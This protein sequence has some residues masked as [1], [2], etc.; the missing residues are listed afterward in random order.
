MSQIQQASL[1]KARG[2]GL[3]GGVAATARPSQMSRGPV[4]AASAEGACSRSGEVT[5]P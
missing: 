4:P 1:G 5:G 2:L 3:R